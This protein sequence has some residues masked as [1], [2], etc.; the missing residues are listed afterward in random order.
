MVVVSPWSRGGYVNSQTFDHTSSIQFLEHFLT[1]KTGK[2]IYEDNISSWRRSLCGDLT[3]VF[4]PYNGEHIPLPKAVERMPFLEGIHKAKFAKLPSNFK[5]LDKAAI[6]GILKNPKGNPNLPKQEPG[7]KPANAI[8]YELYADA[9]LDRASKQ[10]KIDFTAGKTFFGDKAK[11]AGF[12]VY[13][14]DKNWNFTVDA[15]DTIDYNWPLAD[16]NAET[17]DLKVYSSNGFYRR[18]TGNTHDPEIAISLK[19]QSEKDGRRV[20]GNVLLHIRRLTKGNPIKFTIKDN[21]YKKPMLKAV[22]NKNQEEIFIPIDLK[23]SHSWYDFTVTTEKNEVYSQQFAGHA[24]H[25]KESFTDPLMG[26]QY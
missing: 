7:I 12:I 17:Y 22:L 13:S 2:K 15:G 24:E 4:R 23:A 21:S 3:S 11:G 9:A 14:G 16:F 26:R 25:A 6:A 8:P 20:N 18:Y 19:Y 5:N 1:H 10:F